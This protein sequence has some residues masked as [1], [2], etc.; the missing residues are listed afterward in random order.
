VLERPDAKRVATLTGPDR[1]AACAPRPARRGC[2][3][4]ASSTGAGF[5]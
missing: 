2:G 4:A 1:R 3:Y 5:L